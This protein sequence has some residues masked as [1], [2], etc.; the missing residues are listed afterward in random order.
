MDLFVEIFPVEPGAV[1]PLTAYQIRL[2]ASLSDPQRGRLGSRLAQRLRKAFGGE[3]LW[4]DNRLLTDTG[5][6]D[7]ELMITA[8]ILRA[9]QP[10]IFGVLLG[11]ETDAAWRPPPATT[12]QFIIRTRLRDLSP[13]MQAALDKLNTRL[14]NARTERGFKFRA[15]DVKGQPAVS[16]SILSRL[17][18]DQNVQQFAGMER[19]PAAVGDKLTGLAV[20]DT[21]SGERGEITQVLGPLAD[22]RARLLQLAQDET[23]RQT[24]QNAL[25]GE[26]VIAAQFGKNEY[27]FLAS[28]LQLIVRQAELSRFAV[29][30][31]QALQA[32]QMKPAVRASQVKAVSDVA[33]E[34]GILAN[35][36]NSRTTPDVFFSADFEMNL[37]FGKNRVRPYQAGSLRFD[38]MQCGVYKMRDRFKNAPVK[39]CV[40]NTLPFKL[41]DFVEAMRRQ[42]DRNFH[43]VVQIIRE[44]Q[45]RVVSRPNLES[46]VRVVEK[47]NPDI[48]LAFFPDTATADDDEDSD[49]DATATY[50]KSLTLGRGIPTH[51]IH[52][53]TLNDPDAMPFIIMNILGKTGNAPFVLAEPLEHADFV[54]GLD[55]VR[56]TRKTTGETI[57]TAI[58]RI[59]KADGEFLRYIV[60]SLTMQGESLPYVLMRDLFPQREF[61]KKRVIVHHDGEYATDLLEALAGWGKAIGATFYP[62]EIVRFGSPRIY[63]IQNGIVQPPWGSAFKL[64]STEALLISSLPQDDITPQPLH[65]R[66]VGSTPLPIEKALRGVL[67]WSVLAYAERLPKLPVTVMNTQQFAYW[68][69]KGGTFG[70][71]EGDVPFWL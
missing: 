64:S 15:W 27:H 38:F 10:G 22:H 70:S 34:A 49:T 18:Y 36:Y 17:I 39:I 32:L 50:I 26:W 33:K 23:L 63:A 52:E 21:S 61:S 54:V 16:V 31:R 53:S 60:R 62:V 65:I 13:I 37:R 9:E 45:V 4:S 25:D 51:V 24:I 56:N 8:D 42:L 47:E 41:E 6:S 28:S 57:L 48:I 71:D 35:A 11:I 3:W 69:D 40:V 44:R 59:Y 30:S 43:F 5:R 29:D 68:L 66:A 7:I 12:A 46:A 58:T 55:V 2:D 67:V 19:D 1:P 14:R 20:L